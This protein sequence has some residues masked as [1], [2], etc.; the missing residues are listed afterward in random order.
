MYWVEIGVVPT[1]EQ[2][3][4]VEVGVVSTEEMAEARQR[5][6]GHVKRRSAL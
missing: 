1:E 3:Y 2:M 6:F 4:W 5:W